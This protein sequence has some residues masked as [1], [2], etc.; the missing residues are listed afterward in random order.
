MAYK[1]V[2]IRYILA[3]TSLASAVG[4]GVAGYLYA[5]KK[6]AAKYVAIAEAEIEESKK[7]YSRLFKT[8]ENADP[9]EVAKDLGYIVGATPLKIENEDEQLLKEA[10][11]LISNMEYVPEDE[12]PE[13][14]RV[15]AKKNI[16]ADPR[17]PAVDVVKREEEIDRDI[18]VISADD[19]LGGGEGEYDQITLTY[20]EQ[21]DTLVGSDDKP[22][23]DEVRLIG[24]D[25]L[26]FGHLSRDNNV[27]YI[28]NTKLEMD[29]E[30]LRSRGSYSEEV[31]GFIKHEDQGPRKFRP[32]D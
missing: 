19:F 4:G 23:D 8:D 17:P 12:I 25:N 1:G 31:L 26:T 10:V 20:F 14:K 16:F 21:D 2:R 13:E 11:D 7:F 5:D 30:V 29:F 27:V 3:A 28:R 24:V 15:V 9:A 18:F 6:L 32:Y 22:V